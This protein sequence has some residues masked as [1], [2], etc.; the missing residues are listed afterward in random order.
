MCTNRT[1]YSKV[2][3]AV[4]HKERMRGVHLPF[5]GREPVDGKTT[6][7]SVAYSVMHGQ[8]YCRSTDQT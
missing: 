4:H 5:S 8:C 7:L 1:I 3:R 6:L 2:G